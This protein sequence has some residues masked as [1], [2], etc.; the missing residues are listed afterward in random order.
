MH[1]IHNFIIEVYS[2]KYITHNSVVEVYIVRYTIRT[3]IIT[4]AKRIIKENKAT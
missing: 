3:T 4:N 2:V 1:N